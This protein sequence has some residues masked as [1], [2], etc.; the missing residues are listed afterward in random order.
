MTKPC[1]FWSFS[2]HPVH[3]QTTYS[4]AL[5]QGVPS[6]GQQGTEDQPASSSID[7]I[8]AHVRRVQEECGQLCD[9]NKPITPGPFMGSVT[10]KV[11]KE[12]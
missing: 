4:S 10:A 8:V 9:L 6:S 3:L 1:C 12:G 5:S 7:P 2:E 11:I